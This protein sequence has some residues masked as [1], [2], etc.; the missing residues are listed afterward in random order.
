MTAK[1][2]GA[3][4]LSL[5]LRPVMECSKAQ[6]VHQSNATFLVLDEPTSCATLKCADG[7][8]GGTR[9]GSFDLRSVFR[10]A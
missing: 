1:S 3:K 10:G 6:R 9:W 2:L 4:T 8:C 5:S 7:E